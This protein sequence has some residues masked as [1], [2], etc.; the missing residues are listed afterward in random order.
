MRVEGWERILRDR[1]AASMREPYALGRSDCATWAL[2]ITRAITGTAVGETLR[3]RYHSR[4]GAVRLMR[5]L[6]QEGT[7]KGA[8][9]AYLQREPVSIRRVMRGDVLL[10]IDS[11]G[12][13]HLGINDGIQG[14]IR[15]PERTALIPL[16]RFDCGWN[17]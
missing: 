16:D 12:E 11:D 4:A 7:L 13:Q 14:A 8:V 6:S 1:L 2:D 17:T 9:T 15:T 10:Y 5:V 3:G